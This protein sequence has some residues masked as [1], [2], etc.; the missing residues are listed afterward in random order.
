MEEWLDEVLLILQEM[1]ENGEEIPDALFA[2]IANA[3]EE[4]NQTEQQPIQ[5]TPA[6]QEVT[7][8][9]R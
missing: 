1:L 4:I 7:A 6:P 8:F 2:E 5:V 3:I 9:K